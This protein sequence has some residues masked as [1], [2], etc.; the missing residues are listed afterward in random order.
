MV[1]YEKVRQALR[2]STIAVAV[3]NILSIILGL[4]GILS[5]LSL[6]R[7]IQNGTIE[8]YKLSA[9]ELAAIKQSITSTAIMITVV[10]V[11]INITIAVFCFINLSKLRQEQTV[12]SIP[13]YLG[14]A[15]ST[16]N[17]AYFLIFNQLAV[18]PLLIQAAYIVLYFYAIQ[19]ARTL[20]EKEKEE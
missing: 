14:L 4:F 7:A 20:A 1:S 5:A 16:F 9:K 19:K 13:Y 11:I 6:R 12:S 15:V 18:L 8:Q 3:L 17:I 2:T 10:V